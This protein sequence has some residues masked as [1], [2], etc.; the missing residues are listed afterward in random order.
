MSSS[1]QVTLLK[2]RLD[3]H[4]VAE[5]LGVNC[6]TVRRYAR[7]GQLP[8]ARKQGRDWSFDPERINKFFERAR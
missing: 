6:D 2:K 5:S 3:V 8:G 4:E 7:T 1:I